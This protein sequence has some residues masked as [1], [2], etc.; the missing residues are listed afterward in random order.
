M[1]VQG[2]CIHHPGLAATIEVNGKKYCQ[3][4]ET[5]QQQAEKLLPKEITQHLVWKFI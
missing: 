1:V 3:R 2:K 5:G 4:C